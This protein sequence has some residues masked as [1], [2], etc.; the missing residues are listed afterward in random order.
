VPTA[1]RRQVSGARVQ[2]RCRRHASLP[3]NGECWVLSETTAA[4]AGCPRCG[5]RA[6][7]RSAGE[8]R[9]QPTGGR[10][11]RLACPTRRWICT[12]PDGNAKSLTEQTPAIEG[13]SRARS[14]RS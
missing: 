13:S 9:G 7:G 5:A 10:P 3:R 8:V 12:D 6:T 4:V 2:R 11:V 1:N 14:A